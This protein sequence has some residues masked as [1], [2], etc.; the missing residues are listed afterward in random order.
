[1]SS[2]SQE[3]EK[4]YS[5][6]KPVHGKWVPASDWTAPCVCTHQCADLFCSLLVGSVWWD[7]SPGSLLSTAT[8]E[9]WVCEC[10]WGITEQWWWEYCQTLVLSQL[11]TWIPSSARCLLCLD[12]W[13]QSTR[14]LHQS[15]CSRGVWHCHNMEILKSHRNIRHT[16]YNADNQWNV[17]KYTYSNTNFKWFSATV[18]FYYT[19]LHWQ[20]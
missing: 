9:T 17:I 1:M 7:R 14:A 18:N 3:V 11:V 4:E 10:M 20:V 16:S 13:Y 15:H 6:N 2:S 19:S 12:G 8:T 5:W